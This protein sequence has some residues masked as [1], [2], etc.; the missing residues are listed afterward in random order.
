MQKKTE[1]QISK[2]ATPNDALLLK[3]Q[4]RMSEMFRSAEHDRLWGVISVQVVFEAGQAKAI[5]KQS[6]GREKL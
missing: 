3:A 4:Q 6:Q 5:T 2:Q 1:T